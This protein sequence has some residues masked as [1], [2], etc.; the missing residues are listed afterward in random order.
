MRFLS[1]SYNLTRNEYAYVSS[2]SNELSL[3]QT[4]GRKYAGVLSQKCKIVRLPRKWLRTRIVGLTKEKTS[5]VRIEV[6]T[7]KTTRAGALVGGGVITLLLITFIIGSKVI[8]DIQARKGVM[9]RNGARV[10]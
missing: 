1:A 4:N 9:I 2:V 5:V 6:S 10:T 7:W 8:T 3:L